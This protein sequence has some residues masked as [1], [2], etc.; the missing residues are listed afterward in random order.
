MIMI[1]KLLCQLFSARCQ[2][3]SLRLDIGNEFRYGSIHRCFMSY[4]HLSSNFTQCQFPSCCMTLRRIYIRLNQTCFL[5]NL[6]EHVPNLEKLLVDFH[7]S[8]NHASSW[9]SNIEILRQSN[10]NWFHKVP[11]LRYFS[12]KT[13]I[14]TD[15]E[16]IYLK[17]LLNNFN[18]VVKLQ[19]H[20]ISDKI[21]ETKSKNIWKSFI[22]ADFIRQYCL[23]DMIINLIDFNFYICT[24]C[25]LSINDIENITN[26]FKINSFF[27][28]HQ[29]TNVKCLF[30]P[31]MSC[32]H[33]F[34][35]FN[36]TL[37]FSNNFT[38]RPCILNWPYIDE[39]STPHHPSLFLF[40]EQ[41][42]NLS[43]DISCINV[44]KTHVSVPIDRNELREQVLAHL[45]SMPVQLKCLR[46]E[47]F[48]WLLHVVKY[49]SNELRMNALSS[50]QYAEFCLP[51]CHSGYNKTNHIGKDLVPFLSTYMPH[52]QTLRLWRPDDFLL[53]TIRP[54]KGIRR[55][56]QVP[57][58]RWIKSLKT[59]KSIARHAVVFE[60][61]LCQL[62]TK[63]KEFTFLD[64]YGD[65]D[66]EKVQ[67]Y[68]AMVQARFSHSRVDVE[69]SRFCLWL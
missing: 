35:S 19:L 53:T 34:S 16:F 42:N 7:S 44:Y 37:E 5:E 61:D 62:I 6:I 39:Y 15:L 21:I 2:L 31:I 26:S 67:V 57:I 4:S 48:E 10:G 64:I 50:V 20:L 59:P 9:S 13:F 46:V 49:A 36:N 24:Q 69:I 54:D 41:F 8:L 51:S 30:D 12:L 25:Q 63:L 3:T 14:Y 45:I 52:L 1:K 23:P 65:I 66:Y 55:T 58:L 47:Q 22:D 68:R 43:P 17:W 56:N 11:K 33:L 27:I 28:S 29:W 60:Q 38:I 32:Q 40:L 18:Y